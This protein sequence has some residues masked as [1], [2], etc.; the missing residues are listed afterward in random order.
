M[1]TLHWCS[2]SAIPVRVGSPIRTKQRYIAK[3]Y[4]FLNHHQ[5]CYVV[6]SLKR[7]LL[8]TRR[9]FPSHI[10][11]VISHYSR[12][13]NSHQ[14]DWGNVLESNKRLFSAGNNLMCCVKS[15]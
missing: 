3:H 6:L 7:D 8:E 11:S 1:N 9:Y 12:S 10:R 5:I 15:C 4:R 14:Q 2:Q 13:F